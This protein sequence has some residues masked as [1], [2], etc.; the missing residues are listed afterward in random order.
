MSFKFC[1]KKNNSGKTQG[2]TSTTQKI[3]TSAQNIFKTTVKNFFLKIG[4]NI[5]TNEKKSKDLQRKCIM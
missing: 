5:L 2:S 4:N 1:I 3:E